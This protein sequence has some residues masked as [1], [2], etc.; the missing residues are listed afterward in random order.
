MLITENQRPSTQLYFTQEEEGAFKL[1]FKTHKGGAEIA[2]IAFPRGNL[3]II[4]GEE[5][6]GCKE[7]MASL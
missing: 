1:W 5:E 2:A 7:V 6:E 3:R 4:R